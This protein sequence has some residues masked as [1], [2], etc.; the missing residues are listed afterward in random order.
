MNEKFAEYIAMWMVNSQ[1]Y[2]R[3]N[4]LSIELALWLPADLYKEMGKALTST[5]ILH[6]QEVIIK[7]RQFV[8]EL[9]GDLGRQHLIF[10]KEGVGAK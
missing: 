9:P 7:V 1:D 8:L 3:M 5:K 4:Q 10:H 6:I 2:R